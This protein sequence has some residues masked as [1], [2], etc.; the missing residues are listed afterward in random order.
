MN[1]L[2][3]DILFVSDLGQNLLSLGQL[4]K[5]KYGLNFDDNQRSIYDKMDDR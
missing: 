5:H 4:L 1:I 2:K 3:P